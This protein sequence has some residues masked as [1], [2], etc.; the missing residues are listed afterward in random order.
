[1]R[2]IVLAI[3]QESGV[4]SS[5]DDHRHERGDSGAMLDRKGGRREVPKGE[6]KRPLDAVFVT[7]RRAALTARGLPPAS[8][9]RSLRGTTA[10]TALVAAFRP[11]V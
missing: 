1:M 2:P 5:C 11:G 8:I 4:Q 10:A 7:G 6:A 3:A 9:V